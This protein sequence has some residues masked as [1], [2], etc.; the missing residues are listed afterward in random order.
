MSEKGWKVRPASLPDLDAL[1]ELFDAY[2][3]F[4]RQASDPEGARQFLSQR[5]E[6]L[7]SVILLAEH[8]RTG[9][10]AGFTQLYPTFS[11][12]SMRR[13]W[14][15]N[16]LY[17]RPEHRG[18]GI[19]GQLLDAAREHAELTGAK[20]LQLSTAP[21]NRTAQKLYEGRGYI[22]DDEYWHYFLTI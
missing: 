13:V 8:A 4:Y 21:D 22:K 12:V 16:D 3:M 17:V 9:E 15:L 20:G 10:A 19:A 11:S 5:L 7:Q 6:N 18:A 14:T 1:T 2:R